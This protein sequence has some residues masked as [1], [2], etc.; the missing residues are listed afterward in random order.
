MWKRN[1][2]SKQQKYESISRKAA[3]V[4]SLNVNNEENAP[5]IIYIVVVMRNIAIDFQYYYQVP[6]MQ[7]MPLHMHKIL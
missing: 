3:N 2:L 6:K 7:L 4:M 5:Y 1:E